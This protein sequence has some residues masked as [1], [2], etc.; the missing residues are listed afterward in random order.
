MDSLDQIALEIV[1]NRRQALA[2][3]KNPPGHV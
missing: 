1:E 2:S 3:I